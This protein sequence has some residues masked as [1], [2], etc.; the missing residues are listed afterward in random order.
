MKYVTYAA[1]ALGGLALVLLLS[2]GTL[3]WS[4]FLGKAAEQIRYDIRKESASYR[5]G[6]QRQLMTLKLQYESADSAGKVGI[7]QAVR[8]QYSQTDTS[9]YPALLQSFLR[10]M[11]L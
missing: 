4:G 3:H 2:Y 11:G 7:R 8:H 5:D 1:M 9:E 6:M 10:D